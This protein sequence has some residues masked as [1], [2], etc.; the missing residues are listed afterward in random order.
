MNIFALVNLPSALIEKGKVE[1]DRG[2][3]GGKRAQLIN[4][5]FCDKK[6]LVL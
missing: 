3:W 6:L 1:C 2:L 5:S 4:P